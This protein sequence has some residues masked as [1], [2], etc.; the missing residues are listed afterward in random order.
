MCDLF[1][2]NFLSQNQ[3]IG[4][5]LQSFHLSCETASARTGI[6]LVH[7]TGIHPPISP[8]VPYIVERLWGLA[9][10]DVLL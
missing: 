1:R 8:N 4:F 2:Y 6:K 9:F 5:P 7:Y 3:T 10:V